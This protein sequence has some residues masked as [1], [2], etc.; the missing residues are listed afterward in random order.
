[1]NKPGKDK[2]KK[3]IL[4]KL[5][6]NKIKNALPVIQESE[7]EKEKM[8]PSTDDFIA[9]T[10]EEVIRVPNCTY[11]NN[12]KQAKYFLCTC[13]SSTKGF[14]PICEA[15]ALLCHKTHHPTL[16]VSG[17]SKCYCGLTN[18]LITQEMESTAKEKTENA[19][20][21]A[22]CFYSKFFDLTPNRG[23]FKYENTIYCAVCVEHCLMMDFD[24]IALSQVEP[25]RHVCACPQFHEINVI[26]LNADFISRKTFHK[27]MRNFN[28][29]IL[30]KIPKSKT[31]YI[32]ALTAQINM[33]VSKKSVNSN[34][35][36]FKNFLV[37]K[38]LELFSSFAV[39]WENKF[40]HVIPQFLATYKIKDL[41]DLMALN[42]FGAVNEENAQNF[43]SGKFYFAELLFNF[44]V[45]TFMLKFANLWNIR[46][47]IN[48]NLFQRLI[49]IHHLKSFNL[50]LK[51]PYLDNNLDDLVGNIL[52][53][54][55]NILKINER[56]DVI[57]R[58]MCYV[59]PTFNRIM[60]YLIKYNIMNDESKKRYFDLVLETILIHR[61]KVNEKAEE[62]GNDK[63]GALKDSAFYVMKSIL[64]TVIYENDQICIDYLTRKKKKKGFMFQIKD[65]TEKLCSI[66]LM[67]IKDFDRREDLNRTIMFDYY[68]RKFLEL[69]LEK[70]DF[71]LNAISNL[72]ED[73]IKE[74]QE[75]D[76][77]TFYTKIKNSFDSDYYDAVSIFTYDM[78]N[79]S[80]QYFSYEIQHEIFCKNATDIILQFKGF[81]VNAR[82]NL[83]EIFTKYCIYNQPDQNSIENLN[84]LKKVVMYSEF[85]QK[86]EEFV[87]IYAQGK[88]YPSSRDS[89]EYNKEDLIDNLHFLLKLLFALCNRD[90][91][92]LTLVMNIKPKIFIGCFYDV[93]D[94]MIAFLER[95]SEM[96][97]SGLPMEQTTLESLINGD[98]EEED[99]TYKYENLYFFSECICELLIINEDNLN[100]LT[101]IMR[102]SM[103]S[104]NK[105]T[106][107]NG[108][109]LN[110]IE[111]FNITFSAIAEKE[112]IVE[113]IRKVMNS[114][115]VQE[116]K[117]KE[118]EK[119]KAMNQKADKSR[120]KAKQEMERFIA[121]YYDFLSE[122][123]KNDMN[124]FNYMEDCNIIP[125]NEF[126]ETYLKLLEN[127][128]KGVPINMKY[129][130]TRYYLTVKNPFQIDIRNI[131]NQ[132]KN[133][134]M[135]GVPDNF[136]IS[137]IHITKRGISDV[138]VDKIKELIDLSKTLVEVMKQFTIEE[139]E[140]ED[141]IFLL[142]YYENIIVRPL[143][144]LFNIFILYIQ[145]L[146]GVDG[147][148]FYQ[149]LF[150]FLK[151]T[152][153]IYLNDKR[154]KQAIEEEKLKLIYEEISIKIELTKSV[155]NDIYNDAKM[156]SDNQIK[157]FEIQRLYEIFHNNIERVIE[158]SKPEASTLGQTKLSAA[159][160]HNINSE[161]Q[162]KLHMGLVYKKKLIDKYRAKKETTYDEDLPLIHSYIKIE[163]DLEAEPG[164]YLSRYFQNK[165]CDILTD[166]N[167]RTL[168]PSDFDGETI[169][170][171]EFKVQNLYILRMIND[172]CYFAPKSF[173]EGFGA[174]ASENFQN[175]F[176]FITEK[177]I[178][179]STLNEIIKL[180]SLDYL[181]KTNDN[182]R[183]MGSKDSLSFQMG[184]NA[185]KLFQNLCEGN[186]QEYQTQLF[187][188]ILN[189]DQ[190]LDNN[191]NIYE[192]SQPSSKMPTS[193]MSQE[194]EEKPKDILGGFGKLL[195][196]GKKQSETIPE[197]QPEIKDLLGIGNLI[198][199]VIKQKKEDEEVS[200][201]NID[202]EKS[203][204]FKKSEGEE[205]E[206]RD[207]F[208]GSQV[209]NIEKEETSLHDRQVS[210]F[211]LISYLM[212]IVN[213]NLNVTNNPENKLLRS[214]SQ[215]KSYDNMI[216]LY[217]RYSD[218]IIEMIQGTEI[219]N[220]KN[221]Y[222]GNLPPEYQVFLEDGTFVENPMNNTFIFL[223]LANQI[224]IMLF[225]SE[226]IF[227]KLSFNMKIS[228]F[229]TLNNVLSQEKI[230]Y[231]IV[232]SFV[233]LFPCDKL[234]DIIS[235]YLRGLYVKFIKGMTYDDPQF[236]ETFNYLELN[237][238][239]LNEL[240]TAFKNNAHIYDDNSFTLASQIFLFITILGKKYNI[241]EAMKILKYSDKELT[242]RKDDTQLAASGFAENYM[243][244]FSAIAGNV[245]PAAKQAV[246]KLSDHN[247]MND[248]IVSCR[249]FSKC[250][251]QCEFKIERGSS[252][253]K[254]DLK[255]I[256]FIVDPHVYYIS[257]TNI[258]NF[259]NNVDRS[260][261][262]TKL[263]SL[264]DELNL[265][266][267]EVEYKSHI[268]K[269]SKYIQ[270]FLAVDYKNVYFYN[271]LISLLINCILLVF[272]TGNDAQEQ[273]VRYLTLICVGGQCFMNII[274]LI[275]FI[276]SKYSFYVLLAKNELGKK[277][278]LTFKEA[279][280]V[281]CLD[282]FLLNDEVDLLI[283]IIIL[284]FLGIASKY[285]CFFFAF[286]LLTAIKF[287]NTMKEILIAVQLRIGALICMM[288][289]LA[290]LVFFYANVG[291][292]FLV[293]EFNTEIDGEKENLCKTLLECMLLYFNHGVRSGG[294]IGDIIGPKSFNDMSL[295]L[296]RWFTD[297]IFYITV[298]L[299]LLNMINGY[300][301]S[302][303]SEIREERSL[304]EEDIK[305]KCFICNIDRIDFEKKKINFKEHQKYEHNLK[306][307]IKFL[308]SAKRINEKDLDADQGFVVSCLKNRD[309]KCF[310]VK[311][312][313]SLGN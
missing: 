163:D 135:D 296:V 140:K 94:T 298:V 189:K 257:K 118:D 42:D 162:K 216:E 188:L 76:P 136:R 211:N 134:F 268:F 295:Y 154:I 21:Q 280:R 208:E 62:G 220:F 133:I 309:I 117:P 168:K 14:E 287:I 159:T 91:R 240:K 288:G 19:Q 71:Y 142:K 40:F 121:C 29:N 22:Q 182:T 83:E 210:F 145:Q 74:I 230:N 251:K 97:Y 234:I 158:V 215:F 59:F 138:S 51:D 269:K 37:F 228:L 77:E 177:I 204:V 32:D 9:K 166:L 15:C 155:L 165:F 147:L 88:I 195:T 139:F 238:S 284:G 109:F 149:A 1:M 282:S 225:D 54:Y 80:R 27:H 156:F 185:I 245:M 260:S 81:V 3:D 278:R 12:N 307:Y 101:D 105:I 233:N 141:F 312:A 87:H 291:F 132:I 128:F 79:Y 103:K 90:Y 95:L 120:Q 219:K 292:Y 98:E 181:T 173:R 108:D 144:L 45:R 253:G 203:K 255:V 93:P 258:E 171:T 212:R 8:L 213:N 303:F 157:Y 67:I 17:V 113:K 24:D 239:K 235:K 193:K 198:S 183:V 47:I 36:F 256:Y 226:Q 180:Y 58:I 107:D 61:D 310:P 267:T 75:F 209:S 11:A 110:A 302:A 23:Y 33:Y 286:Q 271:F 164:V 199:G 263:K 279:I 305:N 129:A 65:V 170:A 174:C 313:K 276:F 34:N 78:N 281:Y 231:A 111:Q 299:L 187:D 237:Q 86:I 148:S 63:K 196:G 266:M 274:F 217:Q 146:N 89:Y 194:V 130:M 272:L 169:N 119:N 151:I 202:D 30:F 28:F 184:K 112:M 25:G 100:I 192:D 247:Y 294:G 186:F 178:T 10:E 259:Y 92:F 249:F 99:H 244:L 2:D 175:F 73:E 297:I 26:K 60:K 241:F 69:M 290:I 167:I 4:K 254:L 55:D 250:I 270:T 301:V 229:I 68:V 106:M 197:E 152:L 218:L 125:L 248:Y 39:F 190:Y 214:I 41:F 150:Y 160:T 223:S 200:E 124:F 191:K 70:N 123:A 289:F 206:E 50:L 222:D 243:W 143:Y 264:I 137:L 172:V 35:E 131:S 277:K 72:D 48:M 236:E 64:Y 122:L 293:D 201:S 5:G 179:S 126:C 311:C 246:I 102:I 16:E 44:I 18:H 53:L 46:T 6:L 273:I 114:S 43:I 224:K 283:L 207:D 85:F 66:F 252:E 205:D 304:K 84:K 20:T 31:I 115:I 82:I 57:D 13:T 52:D 116:E 300:I 262:T 232:K 96:M 56:Y 153:S 275:I 104:L 227:N 306:H 38:I 221:I 265:F 242:L 161:V 285:G 261:A 49:Y 127:G 308:I 176:P 7:K